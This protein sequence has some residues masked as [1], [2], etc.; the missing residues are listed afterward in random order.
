MQPTNIP[1]L[2]KLLT[3]ADPLTLYINPHEAFCLV[4]VLQLALR[5]PGLQ[6]TN[7]AGVVALS[8]AKQLQE[9]LGEIHPTIAAAL[10]EWDVTKNQPSG[11]TFDDDE[12]DDDPVVMWDEEDGPIRDSELR[13]ICEDV[14]Q[15]DFISAWAILTADAIPLKNI[16]PNGRVPIASPFTFQPQESA[17][18]CYLVDASLLSEEQIVALGVWTFEV[19]QPDCATAEDGIAYVRTGLPLK[20]DWF[21]NAIGYRPIP[22]NYLPNGLPF[23]WQNETSE[24]LS[25]AIQ[26]YFE[27]ALDSAKT[28]PTPEQVALIRGFL[29]H[30]INEP[31]WYKMMDKRFQDGLEKLKKQI[32]R[33]HEVQDISRCLESFLELGLDPL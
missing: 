13:Q 15:A 30:Y 12:F 10:E 28:Q 1:E 7:V 9:R 3:Q 29:W 21:D 4:G 11:D 25:E 26:Y 6:S 33:L 16:F 24:R 23:Q 8:C 19:H 27:H 5:H 32:R 17:P 20:S 14:V 18:P 22:V 2:Q 31:C